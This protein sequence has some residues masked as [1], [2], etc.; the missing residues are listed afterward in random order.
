MYKFGVLNLTIKFLDS[1]L[2]EIYL[3]RIAMNNFGDNFQ[4]SYLS[5]Q[6][7]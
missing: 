5:R 2:Q 1:T 6:L 4:K 3:F 7:F